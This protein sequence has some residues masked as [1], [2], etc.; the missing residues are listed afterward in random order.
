MY[1]EHDHAGR[2]RVGAGI[3]TLAI[4]AVLAAGLILGLASGDAPRRKGDDAL[5]TVDFKRPPPPP[6]QHDES[7]GAAKERP[8]PEGAKGEPL[9]REAPEVALPFP[10][11]PAAAVAG[12]GSDAAAGAGSQ[13]TGTGA[14][15]TGSGGGG[16]GGL[17]S[18][19]QRIA[20][21]L[22]D[23]DYPRAAEAEGLAGTVGIS[24]RVRTDG[25]VDR[26]TVVRS[27]GSA[28]L[29]DLTCRLFTARYRFRPATNASGAATEST[30]QTS[31]TWGTRRR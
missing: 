25:R 13:G 26:C 21:A 16:G 5:V 2:R 9:P 4:H 29:D 3:A 7:A 27:S 24:F 28:L 8:A 17:G 14:G 20:G 12:D 19:A 30:L 22:R 11:P 1:G 23:S 18:P 31:F 15:G 10:M 6:P